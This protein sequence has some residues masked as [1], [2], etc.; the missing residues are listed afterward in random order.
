MKIQDRILAYLT[1]HGPSYHVDVA[2]AVVPFRHK[3]STPRGYF[4][5][6]EV[7][8]AL[9]ALKRTGR[10]IVY[11]AGPQVVV[12]LQAPPDSNA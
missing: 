10:I 11:R 1:E 6:Y 9:V 3:A 2:N 7:E 12:A 4:S 8:R 5:W